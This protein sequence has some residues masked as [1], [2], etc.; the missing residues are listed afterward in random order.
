M[1]LIIFIILL[2]LIG[3][4]ALPLKKISRISYFLIVG[5]AAAINIYLDFITPIGTGFTIGF[6]SFLTDKYTWIFALSVNIS[7]VLV[8]FY[9]FAFD[10]YKFRQRENY[11]LVF[12]HLSLVAVLANAFAENFQTLLL[13]YLLVIPISYPLLTIQDDE[14]C[15][16]AAKIYVIQT[17]IPP[18]LM[19]IPAFIIIHLFTH[20]FSFYNIKTFFESGVDLEVGIALLV[21]LVF[22]FSKNCIFPFNTW[23]PG[24]RRVPAPVSGMAHSVT[25][26]NIGA[27]A[28]IKIVTSVFGIGYIQLL[29]SN[30]LT[31]GFIIHIAGATAIF[32]AYLAY[33]S[34]DL[35]ERLSYSTVGQ[36]M[37]ILIGILIGTPISIMAASLHMLTHSIAKSGLFYVAG[38]FDNFYHTTKTKEVAALAPQNIF[39]VVV[40]GICGLSITGIPFLAG[41]FSK[42]LL[43]V[44]AFHQGMFTSVAYLLVGSYIN[45][46][47][48]LPLVRAAFKKGTK[49]EWGLT[50]IPAGMKI[51]F[52]F[53]IIIILSFSFF[54]EDISK[55]LN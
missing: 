7:W 36:L 24:L 43:M 28:L 22:G 6:L 35:K 3:I 15:K 55:I 46:L 13:F 5:T 53:T 14:R 52:I 26:V 42:D 9:S 32:T 1:N 48:I 33:K 34:T 18:L 47:Y 4:L 37:Y 39:L 25:T 2:P 49:K 8:L 20:S 31:G 45:F 44:E 30:F 19:T 50:E 27:I 17:I 54:V 38:Y 29:T 51:V 40:V 12:L 16:K 10:K 21:L 23:L 11:Y 41:S